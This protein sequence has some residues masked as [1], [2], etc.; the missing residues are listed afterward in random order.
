LSRIRNLEECVLKF[1]ALVAVIKVINR[2]KHCIVR[3]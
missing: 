1:Y 3:L 2:I